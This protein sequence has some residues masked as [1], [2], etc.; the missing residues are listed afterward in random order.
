M[1]P[2]AGAGAPTISDFGAPGISLS[3]VVYPLNNGFIL[4]SY[5]YIFMYTQ[6]WKKTRFVLK[7]PRWCHTSGISTTNIFW[8][9]GAVPKQ[10]ST[11][12]RN[13]ITSP[14]MHTI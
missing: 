1:F 4:R 6:V 14:I 8:G 9:A 3:L 7:Q 2:P 12:D 13:Q 10:T 5:I 11:K